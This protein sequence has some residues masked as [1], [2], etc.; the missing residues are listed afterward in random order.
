MN[1][2]QNP[3]ASALQTMQA[4]QAAQQAAT[5]TKGEIELQLSSARESLTSVREELETAE[6]SAI[7][8]QAADLEQVRR[9]VAALE[10]AESDLARRYKL[11]DKAIRE[12]DSDLYSAKTAYRAAVEHAAKQAANMLEKDL[13]NSKEVRAIQSKLVE[14]GGYWGAYSAADG[15]APGINWDGII[16]DI[17]KAPSDEEHFTA[18][19]KANAALGIPS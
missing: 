15:C 2:K 16:A 19:A 14:I 17:F 8:G 11:C 10:H 12:S 6:I 1:S 5:R 13:M 18:V 7:K 3:I 4:A 9:R